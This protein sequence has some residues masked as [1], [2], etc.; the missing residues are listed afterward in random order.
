M[1]VAELIDGAGV[2]MPGLTVQI[3]I[4]SPIVAVSCFFLLSIMRLAGRERRPVYQLE[5]TPNGR[6]SH[7]GRIP[8]YGPHEH[9]GAL[10]PV[11]V[12]HA[13]VNCDDW[14]GCLSWF[15]TRTSILPFDVPNPLVTT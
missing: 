4:K 10:E 8:I 13:G 5:V 12:A 7:N 3:E 9:V 1:G 11:A 14:N 15:F 6:R 2:T